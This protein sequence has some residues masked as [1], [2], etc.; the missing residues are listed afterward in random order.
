MSVHAQ[1]SSPDP[2]AEAASDLIAEVLAAAEAPC[3]S[4][5]FQLESVVLLHLLRQQ[6]PDLPV[7]FLDTLHHFAE[8]TAYVEELSRRWRLNLITLRALDPAPG[9]WRASTDECCARHKVE[10]LFA[11]LEP[12]DLWFTRRRR[13]Q[14]PSRATLAEEETFELPSGRVLRKVNPLAGWSEEAVRAYAWEH[15]IPLLPL[16]DRGYTSIGCEPCTSIP[17]D[18]SN[19]RSG[20]WGGQKL[21]C[22]IH[23][24]PVRWKGGR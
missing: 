19:I 2:T 17:A 14:S 18:P 8:T 3:V 21:E 9:L 12:Y 4:A 20:R 6:Q 22:G 13:A 11:A 1:L 7:L 16:Y 10:P 24:Q 5:S 23:L 15:R